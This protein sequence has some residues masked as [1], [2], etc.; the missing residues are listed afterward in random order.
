MDNVIDLFFESVDL[1]YVGFVEH[2]IL[3]A[4]LNVATTPTSSIGGI[5]A[6]IRH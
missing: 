5:L 4:I 3:F 6:F 1:Q 2:T